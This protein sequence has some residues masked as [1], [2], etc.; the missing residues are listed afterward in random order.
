MDWTSPASRL[1]LNLASLALFVVLAVVHTWPLASAPGRLS[2]NDNGDTVLHEWTIAWVAHQIVRDPVHLFDANI[3]YPEKNTLAYSDHL[4]VQALMVA[5]LLWAGASPVLC[6]NLLLIAGFALTGWATA[7]AVGRWTGSWYAGVLSGSLAAFNALTLTRLPQIQDQHLEFFPLALV[8]LDRLLVEPRVTRGL[9]LA[10]WYVL[11]ALTSGYILVFAFLSL[12]AGC[13]VRPEFWRRF[14]RV[15]PPLLLASAA[16]A[17]ALAPFMIPYLIVRRDQGLVRSLDEVSQYSAHWA[18]YLATGGRLHYMLWSHR[19]F[20]A[21]ALF[22]GVVALSL[23]LLALVAGV[24]ARDLRARMA[25][26]IA[27]VAFAFSFG[28]AFPPY[29]LLYAAFPLL[30]GIRGAARFG[31]FFLIGIA[32]LA[33]F[34]L[35]G[36]ERRTR[37]G[38]AALCLA[39]IAAANL[40]ALR[41]PLNYHEYGG[42][43]PIYDRLKSPAGAVIAA[44]PLYGSG[45]THQNTVYMLAS[46]RFWKPLINGYSGFAPASYYRAA[47]AL[48]AFPLGNSIQYLRDLGVTHVVVQEDII[49]APRLAHI[50]ERPE[51]SLWMTDGNV[52]IYTLK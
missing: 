2:R 12:A 33:G 26:A 20:S 7:L 15:A 9:R 47:A 17:I 35:A 21:D 10:A 5:P 13:V 50:A 11:Q 30:S 34:G 48:D 19:F 14:R 16:A 45:W 39:V 43:P 8:A 6:Y 23:A 44:L 27:L 25:L 40:E 24:A 29:R 18:D 51:L 52:R 38:A 49:S 37:R 36:I 46:T 1:R 3:F 28:T 22:P 4:V 32:I 42:I 31:Q 41:A